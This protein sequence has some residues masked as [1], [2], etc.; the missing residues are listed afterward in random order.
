MRT[1]GPGGGVGVAGPVPGRGA[2]PP[3][4]GS[5]SRGDGGW[6][7]A[8]LDARGA[9]CRGCGDVADVQADHL[10]PRSQG[11]ESVVANGLPLCGPWTRLGPAGGCHAA[12]TAHRLLIPRWWLDGDQ[13]AWLADAG[14][15]HA[16]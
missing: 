6:R 9:R 4:G 1:D 10:I 7:G 14:P 11:G 13:V 2:G 16:G 3:A 5:V 15:V 8:V 12:K